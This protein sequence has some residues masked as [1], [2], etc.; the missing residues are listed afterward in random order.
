MARGEKRKRSERRRRRGEQGRRQQGRDDGDPHSLS[1]LGNDL[2]T[3]DG[4]GDT[5]GMEGSD[6]RGMDAGVVWFS[7]GGRDAGGCEGAAA[8]GGEGDLGDPRGRLDMGN[9]TGRGNG[10]RQPHARTLYG[11]RIS[12]ANLRPGRDIYYAY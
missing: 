9:V 7:L 8:V 2:A 4:H 11:M 3:E 5:D 12:V 10:R 1:L 6:L